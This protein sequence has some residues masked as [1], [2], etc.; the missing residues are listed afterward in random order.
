MVIRRTVCTLFIY[1]IQKDLYI[2][3][4]MSYVTL[5]L[6]SSPDSINRPEIV[7]NVVKTLQ[8]KVAQT[9]EKV[10]ALQEFQLYVREGDSSYI[11]RH[12]KYV[13]I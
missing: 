2:I 5:Y 8:S 1:L 10:S 6:G 9:S 11:K 4:E 13:M 3:T 12:F 7:D